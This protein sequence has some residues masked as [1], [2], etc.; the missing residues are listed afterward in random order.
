MSKFA[1]LGNIILI[2][3]VGAFTLFGWVMIRYWLKASKEDL[4]RQTLLMACV[5]IGLLAF[6]ATSLFGLG[7]FVESADVLGLGTSEGGFDFLLLVAV[8]PGIFALV[9]V[10]TFA[11]SIL[12]ARM[13]RLA[14]S[15]KD[16]TGKLNE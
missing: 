1:V 2:I 15:G 8:C 3:A 13:S 6:I 14:K 4:S 16:R 5:Q 9:S 7:M 11:F 12:Q 10:G